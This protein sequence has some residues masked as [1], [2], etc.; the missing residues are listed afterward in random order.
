MA[1][2]EFPESFIRYC[3]GIPITSSKR[4]AAF[5][6]NRNQSM[7]NILI[8]SKQPQNYYNKLQSLSQT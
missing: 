7:N 6:G 1:L 3:L 5:T 4:K 8:W 2:Q